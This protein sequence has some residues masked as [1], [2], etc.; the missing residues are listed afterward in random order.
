MVPAYNPSTKEI[1]AERL[2]FQ[3]HLWQRCEFV[4]SQRGRRDR[5]PLSKNPAWSRMRLCW[6]LVVA[7]EGVS[8]KSERLNVM[9]PATKPDLTSDLHKPIHI[10]IQTTHTHTIIKTIFSNKNAVR[11]YLTRQPEQ[12]D[13]QPS[14]VLGDTLMFCAAQGWGSAFCL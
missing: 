14:C 6:S 8:E 1:E 5:R 9:L 7:F 4:Q 12:P 13:T 2:K 3:G 11:P 10:P